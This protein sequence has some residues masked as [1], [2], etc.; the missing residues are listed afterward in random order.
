MH[1]VEIG[2]LIQELQ[3][4]GTDRQQGDLLQSNSKEGLLAV[5][6]WPQGTT[7]FQTDRFV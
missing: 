4:G 1:P 3:R 6:V 2:R 7:Q 5:P